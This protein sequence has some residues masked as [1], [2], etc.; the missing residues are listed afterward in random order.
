M[1]PGQLSHE[2]SEQH[3]AAE[4]WAD[5]AES[6]AESWADVAESWADVA[7]RTHI[8]H[9]ICRLELRNPP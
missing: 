2:L 1:G 6:W 5:V 4:S 9:R 7:E 3:D 8:Q